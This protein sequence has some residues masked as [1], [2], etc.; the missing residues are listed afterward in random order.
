MRFI[1]RLRSPAGSAARRRRKRKS[2]LRTWTRAPGTS[3]L[4]PEA[5]AWVKQ[6]EDEIRSA[7]V[8]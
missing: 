6:I 5:E 8:R 7:V 1:G 2:G 4:T 3:G